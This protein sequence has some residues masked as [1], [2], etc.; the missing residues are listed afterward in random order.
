[1]CGVT[2]FFDPVGLSGEEARARLQQM[3]DAL[4][5]R[6]PD[7]CGVWFEP[8]TGLGL[9][10]TRL[11]IVDRSP[12]GH[13]PMLSATERFAIA[14]N[15]EIY[16]HRDLR[17]QLETGLGGACET[18][19]GHSD[20]ET[21]LGCFETWGVERT[22]ERAVGMFA[23]ALWDRQQSELIL[24]RDRFGEKPLYYGWQNGVLLFGSE[25]KALRAHPAFAADIDRNALALMLRHNH[26][27][28]PY[29]IHRGIRKL[30]PGT[31]CRLALGR[32]AS[33]DERQGKIRTYWSL[34]AV[35]RA[36][37]SKPFAGDPQE[38]ACELERLLGQSLRG[39]MMADVPLG[40][41]L[42]G[43][44]DSSLVVSSMQARSMRPVQTFTIGFAEAAFN[45]AKCA[46]AVAEHLGTEHTELYVTAQDA[47]D[48][49]P[50]LPAIYDE[51]F[52]D[53]SQIPTF[54]LCQMAR[55]HVTVALSG[56]GGDELFC[57]YTRYTLSARYAQRFERLP[58]L[59][60]RGLARG[61][62]VVP[63][64]WWDHLGWALNLGGA[65]EKA[66]KLGELARAESAEAVYRQFVSH[67]KIPREV[68]LGAEEHQTF[69]DSPEVWL[70]G[71]DFEHKMMYLD[72]VG[73]LPDDILV[74][75]DRAAMATSLETRVPFLDHRIAEFAWSLPLTMKC[76]RGKGK[77]ILR[78]LLYKRV[79]QQLIERPKQGFGVPVGEWLR[80]PLR[81]WAEALLHEKRLQQEGFFDAAR[82]R[83][84]WYEHLSG[85][86]NWQHHLWD[87]L[88]FQAWLEQNSSID[89]RRCLN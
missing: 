50:R 55:R 69:L 17:G 64:D 44:V 40:A 61:L 41:F 10:H 86:Q 38:A 27:P 87:V 9:G 54:L 65:S 26:I 7:D 15:G 68:V 77:L 66:R 3:A 74:K 37:R 43:G 49:I 53:A 31:Y 58:R 63:S 30:P 32:T 62:D 36:G 24:A 67:W 46:R 22:L 59:L 76:Q 1:M 16:N 81:E 39:Q 5:H 70:D 84:K 57:G 52:A 11:A 19:R 85:R 8:L 4:R 12:A 6:G 18:W 79:P 13:Q 45:E 34:R 73:Y 20:T 2:G 88:M 42:S 72:S 21:L 29:S 89:S 82:I 35:A 60:R 71:S 23:F 75:V 33:P 47:L 80:G 48:V 51:P 25:L 83:R 14:F 56:D 78:E 28:A